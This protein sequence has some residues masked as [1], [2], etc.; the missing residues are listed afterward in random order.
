MAVTVSSWC[1]PRYFHFH[2]LLHESNKYSISSIIYSTMVL[3]PLRQS[4][5]F[6]TCPP[7]PPPPNFFYFSFFFCVVYCCARGWNFGRV[8]DC[9]KVKLSLTCTYFEGVIIVLLILTT[10]VDV[11]EL[12]AWSPGLFIPWGRAYCTLKIR[13]GLNVFRKCAQ[14]HTHS[15]TRH[16]T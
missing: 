4:A 12:S 3:L 16:V 6:L 5:V 8:V 14:T 1:S 7:P 11:G 13:V 15:P 9:M 10:V 2:L